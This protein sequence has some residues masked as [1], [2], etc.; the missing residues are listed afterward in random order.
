M[1]EAKLAKEIAEKVISDTRFWTGVIGL[2]GVIVGSVLTIIGNIV[3]QRLNERLRRK[4]DGARKEILKTMLQDERFLKKWR[5]LATLA[6][7]IGA[8]EETTKKLLIE[9]KARGSENDDGLWG[10]VEHHPF[11][12]TAQ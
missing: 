10:L 7:V 3:Q 6:R 8:D 9:I 2:I 12:Q 4:L 5:K 1:D 11:N